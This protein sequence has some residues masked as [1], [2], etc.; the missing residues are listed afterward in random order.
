MYIPANMNPLFNHNLNFHRHCRFV[1]SLSTC[2]HSSIVGV[3]GRFCYYYC[4]FNVSTVP[5]YIKYSSKMAL[6]M[7][8]VTDLIQKRSVEVVCMVA[9]SSGPTSY[10]LSVLSSFAFIDCGYDGTV[11]F[12]SFLLLSVFVILSGGYRCRRLRRSYIGMAS[13]GTC[14]DVPIVQEREWAVV[15]RGGQLRR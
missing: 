2:T 14:E 11:H 7:R 13:R 9:S 15:K 1:I 6:L 5:D 12:I 10:Y 4:I 8:N 3:G